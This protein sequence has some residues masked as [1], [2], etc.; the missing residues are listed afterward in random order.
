MPSNKSEG[1]RN[2]KKGKQTQLK[3]KQWPVLKWPSVSANNATLVLA[4]TGTERMEC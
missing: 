4:R 2:I 3:S 1:G